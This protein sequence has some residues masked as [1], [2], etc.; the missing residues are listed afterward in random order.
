MPIAVYDVLDHQD[1]EENYCSVWDGRPDGPNFWI[2]EQHRAAVGGFLFVCADLEAAII[3]RLRIATGMP[4]LTARS[5]IGAP[6]IG[7]ALASLARLLPLNGLTPDQLARFSL[8]KQRTAYIFSVRNLVAHQSPAWRAGWLR[9]HSH[10]TARDISDP[11]KLLY[12]CTLEDMDCL[13][14]FAHAQARCLY[15]VTLAAPRGLAQWEAACAF[16]DN[17][18]LPPDARR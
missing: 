5:V 8:W 17:N 3:S 14:R 9:Y 11:V 12:V 4:D 18:Q 10:D 1:P 16:F 15:E 7:D 6:K 13:A 2:P